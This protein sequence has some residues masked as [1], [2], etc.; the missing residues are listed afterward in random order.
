MC[1]VVGGGS[2]GWVDGWLV[3]ITVPLMVLLLLLTSAF[4][5]IAMNTESVNIGQFNIN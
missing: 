1:S 3:I 4:G 5:G 2:I